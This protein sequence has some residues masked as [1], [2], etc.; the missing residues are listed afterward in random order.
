MLP[1]RGKIMFLNSVSEK[2]IKIKL[3]ATGMGRDRR[4]GKSFWRIESSFRGNKSYLAQP[5][6]FSP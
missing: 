4:W 1:S 2:K 3:K 5:L 6:F